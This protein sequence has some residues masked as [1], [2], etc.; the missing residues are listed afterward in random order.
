MSLGRKLYCVVEQL[1]G[2]TSRLRTEL[3]QYGK[4]IRLLIVE[5]ICGMNTEDYRNR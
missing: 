3:P 1:G 5:M 4:F 2:G